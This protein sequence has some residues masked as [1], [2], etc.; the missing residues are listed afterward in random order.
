M[1]GNDAEQLQATLDRLRHDV[2]TLKRALGGVLLLDLA[3]LVVWVVR[4]YWARFSI[5]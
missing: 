5:H 1:T 4:A 2:G 3:L